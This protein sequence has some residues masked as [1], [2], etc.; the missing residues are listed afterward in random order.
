MWLGYVAE[1]SS[2]VPDLPLARDHFMRRSASGQPDGPAALLRLAEV[3]QIAPPLLEE[4]AFRVALDQHKEEVMTEITTAMLIE[5]AT[6][7]KNGVTQRQL[8][9]GK[10]WQNITVRG[11]EPAIA[12]LSVGMRKL[13]QRLKVRTS[14]GDFRADMDLTFQGYEKAERDPAANVGVLSGIDMLDDLHH[15]LKRGELAL[16]LAFTSHMKTTFCLNWY[17]KAAVYHGKDV[18]MASLE[19]RAEIIRDLLACLHSTHPKFGFDPT[20]I[21]ITFDRLRAGG[22]TPIEKKALSDIVGD[23]RSS[24]NYG[25]MIYKQPEEQMTVDDIFR[26]VEGEQHS[27]GGD[28]ELLVIDYLGLVDPEKGKSSLGEFANVN[29]AIR[30]AKIKSVDFDHGRGIGTLSP[31]QASRKAYEE[32][33]KAGGRYTL[34][35]FSGANEAERSADFAYYLYLDDSMRDNGE[36]AVGNI[37]ARQSAMLTTQFRCYADPATRLIDN[38]DLGSPGQSKVQGGL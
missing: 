21:R 32:A 12:H 10:G 22:L 36:I 35:G 6:I 16:V 28:F 15:G 23:L 9:P 27:T 8:V 14:Q 38:L 18:A 4:A 34:R 20:E 24:T 7:L 33:E 17:Y 37:K 19:T 26:W 11:V 30:L 25:R 3:E 13:E 29:Q 5:S 31:F 1:R 2:V